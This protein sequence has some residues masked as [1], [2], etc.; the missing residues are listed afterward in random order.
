MASPSNKKEPVLVQWILDTRPWYPEATQTKQ[1]ETHASRA[2][3]LLPESERA[4]VLRYFHVRDAKMSLASHLLKH[5]AITK[6]TPTPWSATTITRNSKTKPVYL[7]P[8]TG[9]EPVSFN[10]THQAGLVALVA[11]ANYHSGQADTG[12]D[13]VCTSE[14]RDRDHKLILTD[15]A[16]WPGFVD[17]HADVFGPG[18]VTYLK[19][20]VLSAVPGL[21]S[22]S[23]PEDLIDGKLRAFYAL[24]ALRE[25][26]I[27]LTGE[28]L[29]AEWLRELEFVSFRPP[30]PTEAWEVP[31]REDDDDDVDTDTAQAIRK[32]DI[33]FRGGKVEDVKMCLRS[34]GPDYM[35][36][37]AVRTP[38]RKE[39]ALGWEL[40][41]YEFLELDELLDFAEANR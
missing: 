6:L 11:V 8:S 18:E 16:G 40:G 15:P 21:V 25:A 2:L 33:R 13:V 20:R 17:M 38:D 39:D 41:P 23:K 37:T 12:V 30:R 27:K 14:R 36:A 3:S 34:M 29:L 28:A 4:S 32:F 26:Y 19:Y 35:I 1:L 10:V 31:A 7:D 24:W 9:Q 22:G 5:Y